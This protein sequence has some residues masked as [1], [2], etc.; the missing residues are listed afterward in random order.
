MK[1][2]LTYISKFLIFIHINLIVS[3]KM[4]LKILLYVIE[5]WLVLFS[6]GDQRQCKYQKI[7]LNW[8]VAI[9]ILSTAN[10]NT[11]SL[12][13]DNSCTTGFANYMYLILCIKYR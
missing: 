10:R 4:T 7:L 12:Q 6:I 2:N 11:I 3:I 1:Q 9:I 5:L 8:L 13:F